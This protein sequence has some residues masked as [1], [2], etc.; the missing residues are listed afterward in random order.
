[1]SFFVDIANF[2]FYSF[3]LNV[4]KSVTL[5]LQIFGSEPSCASYLKNMIE[6]LFKHTTCLLTNIKVWFQWLVYLFF[7]LFKFANRSTCTYFVA[8]GIHY[9]TRHSRWLFSV[10]IKVHS[11]LSSIIYPFCCVSSFS[12]VLNDWDHSTAQV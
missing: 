9:K 10:G 6:A 12:W 7:L 8:A 2:T 5:V 1:M 4:E 11:L 3:W